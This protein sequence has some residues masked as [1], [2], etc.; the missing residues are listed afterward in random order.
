MGY[1]VARSWLFK[2]EGL[3]NVYLEIL[4]I[5]H[6]IAR[7]IKYREEAASSGSPWNALNMGVMKA[8]CEINIKVLQ[9]RAAGLDVTI[10]EG[11]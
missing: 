3:D 6:W 11:R 9:R 1:K 10:I 2:H 4:R 8:R 5:R 7:A